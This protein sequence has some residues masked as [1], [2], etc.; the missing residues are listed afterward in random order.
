MNAPNRPAASNPLLDFSGLPQ[1]GQITPEHIRPAV[2]ALLGEIRA[3]VE[4]VASIAAEPTW[5]QF[6]VPLAAAQDR[7]DR[8]WGQVAHLN[9]VLNTAP[10][11]EAYNASLPRVTALHT[12]IG[13]DERLFAGFRALA[14]DA[15]FGRLEPGQ[16]QLIDNDLRDFRLAGV[17]LSASGKTRFKEIEEE[18]A[19]LAARF[20]DNLLD[21]TN[22]YALYI[23]NVDE[24]AGVPA[25]VLAAARE[26][27]AQDGRPGWK[28]TLRMPCYQPVLQ[29]TAN[30][31]LRQVLHR[32]FA[33][34]ASE[35]GRPEWDN[36]AL[37]QRI[38]ELRLEAARLLGY[39]NFAEVSLVAKMART[40][41]EVLEFLRDL[42]IRARPFAER[43][44]AELAALA[45]D[46]FGLAELAAWDL[47]Y[48]T[49]KL[50]QARYHFSD[51]EVKQYFPEGRVLA[52][53]FRTAETVFGI[54]IREGTAATWH[55]AV[56][57]FDV[58]DA[59]GTL[60]GQF[61]LDLYARS[62]K[63][64]GA[65]MDHAIN[66]R[67]YGQR[68][69][70]P[71]AYLVCNFSAPVAQAAK[72]R[73]A[74]F[75]HE[76]VQTLFH[77]FGHGLHLL[78]TR[79]EVPG[80]SGLE[81]VEWDAVELPSQFMENFCWEWDVLRQM[82]GH[83]DT[84]EP[85]PRELFERMLAAKNFQSGMQ[86]LR[87]VELALFDMHLHFDFNP[88]AGASALELG[89]AIRRQVAVVPNP[90]YDRAPNAF[91]HIFAGGYAAGYYSY[92]WAE[93]LSADAYSLF[94]EKG[95]LS[96]EAGSRF[97]NE[98]LAQGGS[99]PA[100]ESFIAFRGRPPQIDALL[101]HNGMSPS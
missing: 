62:H 30:R 19:S 73:P 96:T 53:M 58:L 16:R 43:D 18:L 1:F 17:E 41:D 12:E 76:E 10:L 77:E 69:Q 67:R 54:R 4:Q 29:Y 48:L 50:R 63:R 27:A 57:F 65:W 11:R 36:T 37:I 51:Q 85:L 2:D 89:R 61:Y 45:R 15:D 75:T 33:V 88:T 32:A 95:V 97:R 82:T 9:A 83:V 91:A 93:V 55:P 87:Q 52:G 14:A 21:A 7:L 42:A 78:L 31:N 100:L 66:R 79:V 39:R 101:R 59:A 5:E 23:E 26:A 80:V 28:L 72:A 60:I 94:E 13:Q 47:P 3:T 84:G 44:L 81:G 90:D 35:F 64:G 24:L 99:R 38:L 68:A 70:H 71:V 92:K 46:E 74:L 98:V 8:A 56:R 40:P 22:D 6:V 20:E 34:R 25:D 49:E 86:M